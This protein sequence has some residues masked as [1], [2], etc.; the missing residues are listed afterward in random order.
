MSR[1]GLRE[2]EVVVVLSE[3]YTELDEICEH[4]LGQGYTPLPAPDAFAAS[5]LCRF[6]RPDAMIVELPN[7]EALDLLR[8]RAEHPQFGEIGTLALVDRLWDAEELTDDPAL[9]V[10]D[11]LRRPFSL[12]VMSARLEAILRR[13]HRR[14]DPVVRIGELLVDPP[15]RKV[16]VGDREVRLARKEFVL[17]RVLAGDPT[18]VFSKDDLLRA[19]WG[20]REVPGQTRTLDSHASRLRRRLDPD[21]DHR[22][23][24]RST[25]R[26]PGTGRTP[27]GQRRR[28]DAGLRQGRHPETQGNQGSRGIRG[29]RRRQIDLRLL[30]PSFP[31]PSGRGRRRQHRRLQEST[32]LPIE[33]IIS[34]W[35]LARRPFH[36]G[37]A[38]LPLSRATARDRNGGDRA[39]QRRSAA[40]ECHRPR[41]EL[42]RATQFVSD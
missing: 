1:S 14:S 12:D 20:L 38:G 35:R 10:D 26:E 24:P 17:L 25:R 18:R 4:L 42:S 3:S 22:A 19:V 41:S 34:V 6:A 32:V 13:R 33:A 27:G 15:R 23:Q 11:R 36:P 2:S 40:G 31:R 7:A 8:G 30:P 39:D 29:K 37:A 21:R 9:A 5:R 16:K 28:R